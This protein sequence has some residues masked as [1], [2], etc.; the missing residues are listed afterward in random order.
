MRTSNPIKHTLQHL[1]VLGLL[2]FCASNQAAAA[3]WTGMDLGTPSYNG[4]VTDNGDGT[5]TI[6]AGG[7]D[8]WNTTD[9][10]YYYYQPVSAPVWDAVVRVRSLECPGGGSTGNAIWSKVEL[11]VRMDQGTGAPE[12]S[13]AFIASMA[14]QPSSYQ[15]AGGDYGVN[16]VCDQFRT[17]P[18]GSADWIYGSWPGASHV[19]AAGVPAPNYPDRWLGISRVGSVFTVKD[20][21]DGVNW[22]HSAVIDTSNPN[23]QP[24]GNDSGTRF[25]TPFTGNL[26]I[27]VAVTSHD[28][29]VDDSNCAVAVISDLKLTVQTDMLFIDKPV[30]LPVGFEIGVIQSGA[31]ILD[32]TSVKYWFDDKPVTAITMRTS[33]DGS[34]ITSRYA[35]NATPLVPGS[36][37]TVRL[38]CKDK[39]GVGYDQT[40]SFTVPPFTMVPAD[41]AVTTYSTPGMAVTVNQINVQRDFDTALSGIDD[42]NYTCNAETQLA[43]GYIDPATGQPFANLADLTLATNG[44]FFVDFVNWEQDNADIDPTPE[45]GPDFFNSARPT[46]APEPNAFIPGIPGTADN[47]TD[48]IVAMTTTYLDLKQ[49]WYKMGVTSDDGFKVSMGPDAPD[50]CGLTLGEVNAGRGAAETAFDLY[51]QQSGVYPTRLLWWEGT[52]GANVEWYSIDTQTGERT[53]V[54][55][56]SANAIKAYRVGQGRAYVKSFLPYPGKWVEQVKPTIKAVLVNGTTT[57]SGIELVVDGTKVTPNISSAGATTT[58]TYQFPADLAFGSRHQHILSYQESTTPPTTRKITSDWTVKTMGVND[59]P[60]A[61]PSFVIEAEDF[62]YDSGKTMPEASAMPYLGGA[63]QDL[64]AVLNVDYYNNDGDDSQVYRTPLIGTGN[65]AQ[66]DRQMTAGTLDVL[67]PGYEVTANVKIGWGDSA[68]WY[69]YTRDIPAGY[70]TAV[71]ALSQGG[72]WWAGL[73]LSLVTD[74]VGTTSQT[75]QYLCLCQ[76]TCWPG[77]WGANALLP[78]NNV[79]GSPTVFHLPGGKTTIQANLQSGDYDWFVLVP[80]ASAPPRVDLVTLDSCK[81]N[82]VVVDWNIINLSTSVDPNTI[83]LVVNGKDVTAK[84][85]VTPNADGAAVHLDD[86]GTMYP[87]GAMPYTLSFKNNKGADC[88]SS[89]FFNVNCYPASGAFVIE[90][91]DFNYTEGGVSGK[92]NP[93]KGVAGMDV[94]VMPYMGGAYQGLDAVNGIDYVST[95]GRDAQDYRAPLNMAP[96]QNVDITASNGN[97]YSND[98]GTWTTTSNYRIGWVSTGEWDNYTRTFPAGDYQVWAALSYD[99]RGAGQLHGSLDM[100]TSDPSKTGQTVQALGVFDAPG[101]AGWGRNELVPM[102]DVAGGTIK[103]V[104]LSGVRTVRFNQGSGDY[105]YLVFVPMGAPPLTPTVK[106]ATLDSCKRNEVTLDWSIVNMD[107]TVNVST[108]KVEV[109]GTDVTAKASISAN[110]GGA[111]VHLDDRGTMYTAGE[112]PWKVSFL[113]SQGTACSGSGTFNVNCYPAEGAFVIEAEDFNYAVDGVGGKTNPQ[114]GVTG[115]DVDVMPYLGDAYKGLDAINGVDYNSTDGRDAQDYRAPLNVDPHQNVQ[116]QLNQDN[117]YAMDRGTYNVTVNYKIGWAGPGK[118]DNYT[119]TFPANNYEVWAALAYDGRGPHQLSGSLDMVTSDPSQT[120]QTTSPL[121]VFDAPGSGGWGRNEL[122]PMKDAVGGTIK[123]VQL[124]GVQTVRYNQPSGDF[125]YLVFVPAGAAKPRFTACRINA[126]GTITI[127]WTGGGTLEVAPSLQPGV[128]WTPVPTAISPYTFT[129]TGK[130]QFGRIKQ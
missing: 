26:F 122:V 88:S 10:G 53:L 9:N 92:T 86:S 77:A 33:P 90:S 31:A 101:S 108:I 98:R 130:M 63:Y 49:G 96:H 44:Q 89:Y 7:N 3:N 37:H 118:W 1:V 14:T 102:K 111:F 13:D 80:M 97:R 70:Y 78:A 8:I 19:Y 54:G 5:L 41:L 109:N 15:T 39:R 22:D 56:N 83:K 18:S 82:E 73:R 117:R 47:P 126:D 100:V 72:Q 69:N 62:D 55:Y 36:S 32:T 93:Q 11:M 65:D 79:D 107:T 6:K 61:P 76:G 94:D 27:G 119:R 30:G 81:R 71:A 42:P 24:A 91:E 35:D 127:E 40:G 116:I 25:N 46:T 103:T 99:G 21:I 59:M 110:A 29:A 121:G 85:T 57:V 75:L 74:G 114:K 2:V 104:S 38:S 64:G 120:G 12:G 23:A 95:D 128:Q 48:G 66:M 123:T 45:D 84:C 20:S 113:D 17:A 34:T 105:D 58:V 50:A 106:F 125:D 4:S 87:A 60:P 43:D 68:D 112:A 51:V 115:L 28:D 129:P 124:G 67:R 16:W 52:G